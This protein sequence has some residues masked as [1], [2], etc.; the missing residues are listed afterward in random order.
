MTAAARDYRVVVADDDPSSRASLAALLVNEGFRTLALDGGRPV[1]ELLERGLVRRRRR[2]TA[3][4]VLRERIDFLVL[5]Y[6]M[7][8][9]NGL[10]VLRQLK[11]ERGTLLP[12]IFVSGELT[13]ELERAVLEVGAFGVAAKPIQPLRFRE[14]VWSLV[15]RHLA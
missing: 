4:V 5:D 9:L 12:T 8:D 10:D 13:V 6:N 2:G 7:P 15:E 11:R 3:R 14:L 1:L